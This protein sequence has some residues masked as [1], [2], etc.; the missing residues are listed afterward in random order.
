M[1]YTPDKATVLRHQKIVR[2]LKSG[3]SVVEVSKE[4]GITPKRIYAVAEREGVSTNPKIY[5]SS[6]DENSIA[7]LIVCGWSHSKI[8][9]YLERET[10]AIT[11][12]VDRIKESPVL[13]KTKQRHGEPET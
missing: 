7:R 8:A 12:A 3:L 6:D 13:K 5:E 10:K 1:A 9:R 4:V 2:L 11:K